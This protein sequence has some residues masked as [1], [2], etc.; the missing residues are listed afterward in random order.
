MTRFLPQLSEYYGRAPVAP[1]PFVGMREDESD[2]PFLAAISEPRA[3]LRDER[4]ACAAVQPVHR[5]I[6]TVN[7]EDFAEALSFGEA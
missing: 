7:G 4:E 1:R 3:R 6:A 5:E 2:W